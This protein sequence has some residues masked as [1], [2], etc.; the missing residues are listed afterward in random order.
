MLKQ[1]ATVL[2]LAASAQAHIQINYPLVGLSLPYLVSLTG[3]RGG[4][5]LP[6]SDTTQGVWNSS[7]GR[8]EADAFCGNGT[9]GPAPAWGT[10]DAFISM[11]GHAGDRGERENTTP[12]GFFFGSERTKGA[13]PLAA[14]P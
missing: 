14:V 12:F 6:A 13:Q 9:R 7:T 11:S 1:F 2:A 5:D 8:Q 3:S 10:R 4:T